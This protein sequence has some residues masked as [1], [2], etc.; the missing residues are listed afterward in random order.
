MNVIGWALLWTVLDQISKAVIEHTMYIGESIPV[1]PSVF[2]LTY[3]VNH[4]AAFGILE[5]QRVFFLIIAALL[6]IG[7]FV[8]CNKL[9]QR[10]DTRLGTSLVLGGALGNGLD[11]FLYHGVRDFFDFRVWPIFNVA[12][13]A[14]MVGMCIW[15]IYLWKMEKEPQ[16]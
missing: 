5:Y 14:I 8:F 10:W 16:K 9:P 1:W 7:Y 6:W 3:I 12:D 15:I 2:H 4:G 13:I 11:R